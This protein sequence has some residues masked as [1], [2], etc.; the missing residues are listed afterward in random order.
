VWPSKPPSAH[1][2]GWP[3]LLELLELNGPAWSERDV[4]PGLGEQDSQAL[5][6]KI[7]VTVDG[8]EVSDTDTFHAYNEG[9]RWY[10][11][12]DD[13]TFDRAKA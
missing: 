9:G 11:S 12:V 2:P 7:T 4:V 3:W 1:L 5:T 8:K 13:E 6:M 10:I